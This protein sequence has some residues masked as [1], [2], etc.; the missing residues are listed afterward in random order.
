MVRNRYISDG[1]HSDRETDQMRTLLIDDRDILSPTI[2]VFIILLQPSNLFST[3]PPLTSVVHTIL[4]FTSKMNRVRL[5]S[6]FGG[7][8]VD[9]VHRIS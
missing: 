6:L 3:P 7:L 5:V 2:A 9:E 8:R 1:I 4:S